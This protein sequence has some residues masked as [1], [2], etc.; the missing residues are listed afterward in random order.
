MLFKL[1]V[2]KGFLQLCY[3]FQQGVEMLCVKHNN[4]G[5]NFLKLT[6]NEKEERFNN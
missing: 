5:S 2:V 1:D 6:I 4:L 3:L